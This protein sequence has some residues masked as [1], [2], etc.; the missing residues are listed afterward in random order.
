MSDYECR[1]CGKC[2]KQFNLPVKNEDELKERFKEY[3][4]FQLKT[5]KIKV[6]F[7]GECEFLVGNKCSKY[8][9]RPEMCKN[10]ICKRYLKTNVPDGSLYKKRCRTCQNVRSFQ[11]GTD[12]DLQS[13]CGNC[14]IW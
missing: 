12:R 1:K 13:V 6:I 7:E 14:W 11:K 5:C 8:E 4:G 2:C 10:F 3:F 9:E